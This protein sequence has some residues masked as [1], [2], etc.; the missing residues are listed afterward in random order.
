M[1]VLDDFNHKFESNMPQQPI[2]VKA[3]A[4]H[5]TVMCNSM[6]NGQSYRNDENRLP[7]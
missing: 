4:V 1:E 7:S 5:I 3:A 2:T 6:N